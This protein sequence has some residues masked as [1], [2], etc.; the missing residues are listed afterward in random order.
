[1]EPAPALGTAMKSKLAKRT[2]FIDRRKT[3]VNL[4]DEFWN[5]LKNIARD[6]QVTLSDLLDGIDGHRQHINF[7]STL[8]LFV[9]EYYRSKAV[10]LK[11]DPRS[12]HPR[13]PS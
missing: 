9:L 11:N 4:E 10:K 5:A 6:R 8:R 2:I 1:M 13:V 3:S 12:D 7:S